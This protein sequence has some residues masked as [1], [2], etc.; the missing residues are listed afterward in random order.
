LPAGTIA[1][2]DDIEVSGGDK[3]AARRRQLRRALAL[4]VA[5]RRR[6]VRREEIAAAVRGDQDRDVRT[7]I[8]SRRRA[9]R[10]SNSGFDVPSDKSKEGNYLLVVAEP[11]TLD[12]AVDAFRFLGLTGQAEVLWSG[13]RSRRPPNGA[14]PRPAGG[15]ASRSVACGPADRRK[16]TA[17]IVQ[18]AHGGPGPRAWLPRPDPRRDR[19]PPGRPVRRGPC[20]PGPPC[21][22]GGADHGPR[23][24][25]HGPRA[26]RSR[27]R[28]R[29]GLA[30]EVPDRTAR[31]AGTDEA[32]RLGAAAGTTTDRLGMRG[33]ARGGQPPPW[34]SGERSRHQDRDPH[35]YGLLFVLNDLDEGQVQTRRRTRSAAGGQV[36]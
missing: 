33:L 18:R 26:G 2:L 17:G 16:R 7:R 10:D 28:P 32:G 24:T 29:R 19:P 27:P 25:D 9:L 20:V 1:I 8:W 21:R 12:E 13:E 3:P 31:P 30:G 15:A 36:L 11:D 6:R 23:T 34:P 35:G 5:A 22:P 4:M 14:P